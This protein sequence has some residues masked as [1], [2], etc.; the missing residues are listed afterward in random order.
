[1]K[2]L[3]PSLPQ[4]VL[5]LPPSYDLLHEIRIRYVGNPLVGDLWM[6]QSPALEGNGQSR[7]ES[8]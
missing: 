6:N 2:K 3:G 1:M 7:S 4:Q 5:C 8:Q